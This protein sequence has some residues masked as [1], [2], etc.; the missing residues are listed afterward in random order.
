MTARAT[1]EQP[2]EKGLEKGACSRL[3]RGAA[4]R[5]HRGDQNVEIQVG[6]QQRQLR[7]TSPR[8]S[9]ARDCGREEHDDH[10]QQERRRLHERRL[11]VGLERLQ[12]RQLLVGPAHHHV[13]LREVALRLVVDPAEGALDVCL[14]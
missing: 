1:H 2:I 14:R 6:P 3:Q 5:P 13:Q 7:V 11:E 9:N 12:R 8:Q 10:L 4:S